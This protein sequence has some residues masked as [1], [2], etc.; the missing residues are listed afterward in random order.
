MAY[1]WQTPDRHMEYTRHAAYTLN[2]HGIR[3]QKHATSLAKMH[4]LTHTSWQV[5]HTPSHT[6][7]YY[8]CRCVCNQQAGILK[9]IHAV[10]LNANTHTTHNNNCGSA[11]A[12]WCC[13]I[14]RRQ[15][16]LLS[17]CVLFAAYI[18]HLDCAVAAKLQ[19]TVPTT[20]VFRKNCKYICDL[21]KNVNHND[22]IWKYKW[23][24]QGSR[25]DLSD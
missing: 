7:L 8:G 13:H 4:F 24:S 15:S 18:W 20:R 19:H 5:H 14:A 22:K 1:T 12:T 11:I 25:P 16:Y 10:L 6:L 17:V 9:I 23:I 2:T 3:H 21:Q